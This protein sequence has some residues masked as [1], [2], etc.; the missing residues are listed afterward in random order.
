[1]IKKKSKT[2]KM[3]KN[4]MLPSGIVLEEEQFVKEESRLL[5]LAIKGFLVYLIVMGAMGSLLSAVDADYH[6]FVLH[7]VLIFAGILCVFPDLTVPAESC[8]ALD[9]WMYLI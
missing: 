7:V 4:P 3:I 2:N 1:M 8:A 6:A 9:S 5:T